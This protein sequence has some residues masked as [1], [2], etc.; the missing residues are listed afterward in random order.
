MFSFFR[1]KQEISDEE[2]KELNHYIS[3]MLSAG[4][5]E[6]EIKKA[7]KKIGW[8]AKV[9]EQEIEK[10]K[11]S[12]QPKKKGPEISKKK[13]TAK[14]RQDKKPEIQVKNYSVKAHKKARLKSTNKKNTKKTNNRRG[15]NK[16][17]KKISAEQA[18]HYLRDLDPDVSFWV[19]DGAVIANLRSLPKELKKLSLDQFRF[20]VNKD[21]NDFANWVDQVI[22]DRS[23]A[24]SIAKIKTKPTFVK[25]VSSR[26]NALKKIS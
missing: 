15:G 6:K 23:L 9:A 5:E 22:G 12:M 25:K 26:V 3:D 7:L 24:R 16:M 20:H 17:P 18:K 21:K 14:T 1:K 19:N 4:F 11:D 13:K 10:A 8:S 2:S